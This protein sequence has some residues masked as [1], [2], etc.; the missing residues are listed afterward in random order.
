MEQ[1]TVTVMTG[2]LEEAIARQ[3]HQGQVQRMVSDG[4]VLGDGGRK[5]SPLLRPWED[6]DVKDRR[7]YRDRATLSILALE[8]LGCSVNEA[9]GDERM[10]NLLGDILASDL[11]KK[12]YESLPSVRGGEKIPFD[13][14]GPDERE[15]LVAEARGLLSA[16]AAAGGVV[17]N[18]GRTAEVRRLELF[19]GWAKDSVGI[20]NAVGMAVNYGLSRG[21]SFDDINVFVDVINRNEG[22][23]VA[24]YTPE[25]VTLRE[26]AVAENAFGLSFQGKGLEG[27]DSK[28]S[29]VDLES[30]L[31]KEAEAFEA[32]TGTMASRIAEIGHDRVRGLVT[33]KAVMG[34]GGTL[35]EQERLLLGYDLGLK[36]AYD[37]YI[38]T[39]KRYAASLEAEARYRDTPALGRLFMRKP[40]PE[41]TEAERSQVKKNLEAVLADRIA[42]D[43]NKSLAR[44]DFGDGTSVKTSVRANN[45]QA[46]NPSVELELTI[47]DGNTGWHQGYSISGEGRVREF[48]ISP[49]LREITVEQ[50]YLASDRRPEMIQAQY[51]FDKV[52]DMVR[53][54]AMEKYRLDNVSHK[55]VAMDVKS[56]RQR[57]EE[58]AMRLKQ[59]RLL[60][61]DVLDK[62]MAREAGEEISD[63]L[64]TAYI[65]NKATPAERK[66]VEAALERDP[67]LRETMAIIERVDGNMINGNA[68][69]PGQKTGKAPDFVVDE[70]EDRHE[71]YTHLPGEI[72]PRDYDMLIAYGFSGKDIR[73]LGVEKRVNVNA[74]IFTCEK[75]PWDSRDPNPRSVFINLSLTADSRVMV[76]DPISGREIGEAWKVLSSGQNLNFLQIH[77]EAELKAGKNLQRDNTSSL[78]LK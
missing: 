42:M 73:R 43:G 33:D 4:Y 35:R 1:K 38:A 64:M 26:Y 72:T 74:D 27:A 25:D 53:C 44:V 71:I 18:D 36:V 16:I 62:V 50:R 2:P 8:N 59:E 22:C 63:E 28:A 65:E 49:H 76:S 41:V 19:Y 30:F 47:Y 20:E 39:E 67:A 15:R 3:L 60:G 23:N 46:G 52:A 68:E 66:K 17:T 14:I 78:G 5:T 51:R 13:A 32:A 58:E 56:F 37:R 61:G 57:I 7:Y 29:R 21:T 12:R 11:A 48:P 31:E 9:S 54:A 40:K 77:K 24:H 34:I 55:E 45:F 6:L 10:D 69:S 75:Q 70:E